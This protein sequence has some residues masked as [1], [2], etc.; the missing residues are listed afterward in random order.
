VRPQD[1]PSLGVQQLRS[2]SDAASVDA[3]KGEVRYFRGR[4]QIRSHTR[5]RTLGDKFLQAQQSRLHEGIT[6][7]F[8][9]KFP[10]LRARPL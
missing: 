10:W 7:G 5:K 4:R 8:E 6:G 1:V 2:R 9:T 3:D